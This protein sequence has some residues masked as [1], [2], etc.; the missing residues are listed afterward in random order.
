MAPPPLGDVAEIRAIRNL[1]GDHAPSISVCSTKSMIGH[2]HGAAGA[3]DGLQRPFLSRWGGTTDVNCDNPD[4][5][6]AGL[7]FTLTPLVNGRYGWH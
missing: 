3:G 2:C 6:F 7:D 1:F 4:E 5:E